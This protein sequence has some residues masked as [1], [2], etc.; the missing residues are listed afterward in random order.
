MGIAPL[1]KTLATAEELLSQPGLGTVLRCR[2]RHERTNRAVEVV[3]P[4]DTV[5]GVEAKAEDW[6]NGGTRL[7]W[8]ISL[9]SRTVTE[10]QSLAYIS[11]LTGNDV[12]DVMAVVPGFTCRVGDLFQPLWPGSPPN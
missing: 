9:R 5:T 8:I 3:P 11:A 2:V 1:P 12:L 7:L 6:I 10:Y 4:G